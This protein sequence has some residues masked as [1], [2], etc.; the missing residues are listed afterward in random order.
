MSQSADVIAV[1]I[2]ALRDEIEAHNRA[3]YM[4]DAPTIPDAEYDRLF[5]ELEELE[6]DHPE[7]AA[8]DSPTRRVGAEPLAA[9]AEVVHEVP[10]LSLGNAFDEAEVAAF[11]RRCR[12]LLDRERIDY[13][14]EPKLDGLAVSL[15][16]EEGRLVRGATRGD[17]TR[18]EDVTENLRTV[19]SIP[20]RLTTDSP[21]ALL[22]VRGEVLMQRDDFEQLNARQQASGEKTFVNP[23]NAAAG[24]LR[25]LDS[26]ITARR[27]LRFFAYGLA[28]I[29]PGTEPETHSA[30]LDL[31]AALG[32]VVAPE[33]DVVAGAQGLLA[34]YERIGR[35]REQLPYDI[36]GVVYKVNRRADQVDLGF[37]SRAPRWAI[38]H[39]FPA[40]EAVSELLDIEV[41][42]GR[43]GALTPVARLRPVFV[44]GVTVT[45]ATLHNEDEIRRKGLKIG[46]QVIVRRAGDVIPEVV[47]PVLERRNG[48]EHEFVMPSACPV[49]GSHVVRA[50]DE[51]VARCS[52]GLFCA[53]QRKQALLHFAGRRA[54]DI[55]GLGDKIVDQLVERELVRT[56]ADLFRLEA[57]ELAALERMGEKSALNLVAAIDRSRNTTLGRFI[58][59]L[60][61]RNVGETT[62]R[63]L[64]AHF[65]GLDALMSA[66]EAS[67][68]TVRDVGPIVARSVFE[69]F[70]EPHNREVIAQLRE[71]RIVW[72][73]GAP[74]AERGDALSG[75]TFVLTGTLPTLSRDEAK[76][77]IEANGGRVTGSVSSKTDFVVAGEEAGSKL[78][79]AESL[80][81]AVLD[82]EGLRALLAGTG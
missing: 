33:R 5:R 2:A 3:Y 6:R 52:G 44:G 24:S 59:A 75:R 55:E 32:F 28:R 61:I 40:Q 31:L 81:I 82:E 29:A 15:R 12:E 76:A 57:A 46:D 13:A 10:M 23:R 30:T 53:A 56:P 62:A 49:C 16:Y 19:R 72:Q 70:G 47:A 17:G 14:V 78:A 8:P 27:P 71:A 35:L 60:G 25:Q 43:T 45:N 41:Q 63:D 18:G 39:K 77:L 26:R 79:K 21:P 74:A 50:E 68:Q 37:V 48:T 64:A 67:L 22:E 7:C 42:V 4:L 58:F 11:D 66:D 34:Y 51:A 1:R 69:F 9:F 80:G 54:M 73:E 38:A 20:L 65:G 36:D